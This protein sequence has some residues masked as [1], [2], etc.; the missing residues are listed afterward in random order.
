MVL[1]VLYGLTRRA[2]A[3]ARLLPMDAVAK[4]AEILALRHR[5]AVL[6]RQVTRP[7]GISESLLGHV[8][9]NRF[10]SGG[11]LDLL[12]EI[13]HPDEWPNI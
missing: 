10:S 5:L 12:E 7:R 8:R 2:F 6:R 11:M 1:S 4:D 3:L 9:E 13:L